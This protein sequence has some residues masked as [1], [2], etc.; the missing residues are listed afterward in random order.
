MLTVTRINQVMARIEAH[1]VCFLELL[2]RTGEL[3]QPS[4]VRY[5][6]G[7]ISSATEANAML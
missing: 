3:Y 4:L 5:L 1:S 6:V 7:Q 2:A